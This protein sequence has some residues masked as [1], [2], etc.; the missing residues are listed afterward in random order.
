ML[1]HTILHSLIILFFIHTNIGN[2]TDSKRWDEV[3]SVEDLWN[4]DPSR[5]RS[6]IAAI[7]LQK[8]ELEEI[9]I[10][11][12]K[13][14]TIKGTE[15]LVDYFRN[16]D[17]SDVINNTNNA[18]DINSANSIC[19]DSVT[20]GN[21]TL[22]IPRNIDGSWKW[23]YTGIE[24]DD[25]IGYSL[26]SLRY[27]NVLLSAWQNS[28]N[29]KYVKAFDRIMKD[30]TI[31]HKLPEAGDRIYE[32]LLDDKVL[33][34]RDIGEVEWRTIQA[35]QRL[36][37]VFPQVFFGFRDQDLFSPATLLLM[38][39]SINDQAGF[40]RKFHKV[41]HNWTT[42]EMN[43]LALAGLAFPEF[44]DSEMWANYALEVMVK[45]INNQV[46]PDGVQK[47]LSTKTQLVALKRFELVAEHFKLANHPVPD[48]YNRR[49]E[50]MYNYLAYSLKPDG[51]QPLNGDSDNEDLR[52]LISEAAKKFNRHDWT[53]IVSN[54]TSGRIPQVGPTVTFPWA[55]IHI[56]R[57]SWDSQAQWSFFDSGPYGTGHQHRDKLNISI[58]AFG[59]DLL[60]DG[61][62]YTHEDYFSFDP[63]V[64][65]GYF[66][67]SF[68]HNLILVDGNGQNASS[69]KVTKQLEEGIDY[70]SNSV[71]DY[72]F[73]IFKD[74]YENVEGKAEHSR[75]V[76]YL[77]HK[78]WLVLDNF[79]TDRPRNLEVLWHYEPNCEIKISDNKVVP[80]NN[81]GANLLIIP[82][83]NIEWEAKIVKGQTEP[84]FQG[85]FS[86][87]YGTKEPNPTVIYSAS[88]SKSSTFAWLLIPIKNNIPN[89]NFQLTELTDIVNVSIKQDSQSTVNITLP[90]NKEVTKVKV[91]L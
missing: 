72:A 26:N 14:D 56:M 78:Y 74:G 48:F 1:T 34:Y 67:S 39:S 57:N 46:Y 61:G 31:H 52:D 76:L 16:H 90:K 3:N 5:I 28:G 37:E 62:R 60:V 21:K 91:K 9:K 44:K 50:E 84:Y 58:N 6:L 7:D 77:H 55:G 4:Y 53:W 65:R 38:L 41:G 11:I 89:I 81:N 23:N 88:I 24:K 59:K 69:E 10:Q 82:M 87:R 8:P 40:L 45:E 33:D 63:K 54:G 27:L 30:W 86:E 80:A 75:S 83:G 35:G 71:Y 51:H 43:G 36:G 22:K 73:G 15:L 42:M 66:R 70:L 47:E 13:G 68:S 17:L 49:I 29:E 20:F 19:Q 85:W 18:I 32:V 12:T 79:E 25:E 64:W 2:I